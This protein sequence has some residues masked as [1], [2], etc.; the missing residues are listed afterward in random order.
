[1]DLHQRLVLRDHK[2]LVLGQEVVGLVGDGAGV[3]LDREARG[4]ELGLGEPGR[5]GHLG[6]AV[7]LV[8]KLRMRRLH[9]IRSGCLWYFTLFS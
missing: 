9:V 2:V 7:Q 8:G 4:V 6:R 5:P 3:V 1:M